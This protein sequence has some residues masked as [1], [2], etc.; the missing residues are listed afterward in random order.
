M[1][2][3]TPRDRALNGA[4]SA[5]AFLALPAWKQQEL[6]SGH[7]GDGAGPNLDEAGKFVIDAGTF[8]F[9][10]PAQRA[11]AAIKGGTRLEVRVVPVEVDGATSY[12]VGF[13]SP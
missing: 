1:L 4:T 9:E 6:L 13:L 3:T 5:A 7:K 8:L 2:A 12:I 11:A 10:E